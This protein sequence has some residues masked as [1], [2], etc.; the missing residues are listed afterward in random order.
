[1]VFTYWMLRSPDVSFYYRVSNAVELLARM[2]MRVT[3]RTENMAY[4]L[5]EIFSVHLT[6]AYGEAEKARE[7][8]VHEITI[9]KGDMSFLGFLT[10][11]TNAGSHLPLRWRDNFRIAHCTVPSTPTLVSH[12]GL[13]IEAQLVDKEMK[14]RC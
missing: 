9:Q 3:Y 1:M 5:A 10:I 11:E 12:L 6:P 8:L 4:T 2:D 14:R 13:T 7:R